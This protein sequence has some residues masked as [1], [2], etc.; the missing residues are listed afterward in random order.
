MVNFKKMTYKTQEALSH[1]Q[2]LASRNNHSE[3]SPYHIMSALLEKEITGEMI[4]TILEKTGVTIPKLK[5]ELSFEMNRLA[6]I[7]GQDVDPRLNTSAGKS[8]EAAENIASAMGDEFVALDHVLMGLS[9]KSKEI[10]ALLKTHNVQ[11]KDLELAIKEVRS[12]QIISDQGSDDRFQALKHYT[13]NFTELAQ[14][15]K[16]D[17]VIGRDEE[18]RRVI[19]VLSRRTKNNPVLIGEPGVGKTAIVE[20]LA[21]RIAVKDVPESLKN[22][23]LLALDMGALIAGAKFRGEFEER[24]KGV[25]KEIESSQGEI[26]LFMDELHTIVGAGATGEGAMDASNLLKPALARGSLHAI[27]ATTFNEYRK[28]IEKDAALERRFQP[29]Q[30]LEPTITDTISILR[31]LKERYETHHG[32]MRQLLLRQHFHID[33]FQI[34]SFQT[35]QLI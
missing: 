13:I 16:L 33:I 1:A 7:T 17:P 24:L 2:S 28:H 15:G 19:H 10:S 34:V 30:V 23:Q 5:G 27:G 26:I 9:S 35:R 18:I 20:G 3:I 29:V 32:K 21:R 25:V 11:T 12:G 6:K 22:K 8:L 14:Q 4:Q 31:G